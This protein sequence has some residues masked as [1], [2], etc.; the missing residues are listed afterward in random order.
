[1][2]K[3]SPTTEA[4]EHM[5]DIAWCNCS[6]HTQGSPQPN[7][8]KCYPTPAPSST[9]DPDEFYGIS[10]AEIEGKEEMRRTQKM[11][12]YIDQKHQLA[13]DKECNHKWVMRGSNDKQ[14]DKVCAFCGF[15]PGAIER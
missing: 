7:C 9:V 10:E 14:W 3:Q 12:K 5:G 4:K 6:C 15:K 1:M 11:A 8:P 2:T 13:I